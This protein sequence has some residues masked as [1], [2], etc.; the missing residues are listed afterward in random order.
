MLSTRSIRASRHGRADLAQF[1][2]SGQLI[3]LEFE[4]AA[5]VFAAF[6]LDGFGQNIRVFNGLWPKQ[7]PG[8]KHF[9]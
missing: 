2:N 9:C 3:S 4:D 7:P 5:K 1:A 8:R 6:L